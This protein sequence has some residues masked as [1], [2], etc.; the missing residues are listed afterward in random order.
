M[1]NS[2]ASHDTVRLVRDNLSDEIVTRVRNM[3]VD[4]TLS[5][6]ERINEVHLSRALGVSR[7]P[8][9]EALSK[10]AHENAIRSVPRIGYF[11]RPLTLKEFE[12]IYAI[13][14]ILDPEALRL[15][16]L[17][18]ADQLERLV[19]LNDRIDRAKNADA[20]IELDDEWHL[21]LI[22]GCPNA[23]LVEFIR[24]IVSR[25]R[26]YEIGLMRERR[27]VAMAT[28]SHRAIIGAL[29]RKDLDAACNEL[30]KNLQRGRAP[31][32]AW[33]KSIEN[34]EAE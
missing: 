3:I 33:L 34:A 7:T 2:K 18:S 32:V 15:A 16:G 1:Q 27:N 8:L 23:V 21:E 9:R 26:R 22:A 14:P 31:I 4:G 24:Q 29:R 13:R 28:R 10:L 11:V 30:R 12:D 5:P 6:G 20:V 25:T 17:P 19:S